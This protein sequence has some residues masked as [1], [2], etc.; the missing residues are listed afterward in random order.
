MIAWIVHALGGGDEPAQFVCTG[1][2]VFLDLETTGI[3][4]KRNEV[5]EISIID[6]EGNILIDSLARPIKRKRW[7]DAEAVHGIGPKEVADSPTLDELAPRIVE[8][9]KGKQ[10]VIYNAEFDYKFI[11]DLLEDAEVIRC[12]MLRYAKFK[13][14][15]N[16]YH[17]NY[18]WHKLIDAAKDIGYRFEG[19]AHRALADCLATR[20]VWQH[21]NAAGAE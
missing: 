11:P 15:W 5:V 7:P 21:L 8:A 20:A 18:R 3:D 17:G 19:E 2:Y 12:C 9:V 4:P 13:G 1:P 16:D 10:V 14:E 6:S